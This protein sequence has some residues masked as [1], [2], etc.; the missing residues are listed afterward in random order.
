V[1]GA[2]RVPQ[3]SL[4]K[5]SSYNVTDDRSGQ[6]IPGN[7]LKNLAPHFLPDFINLQH[8]CHSARRKPIQLFKSGE[9]AVELRS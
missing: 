9:G 1:T 8:F 6:H 5:S 3:I 4:G 7:A 2:V